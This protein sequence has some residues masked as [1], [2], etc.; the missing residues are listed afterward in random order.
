MRGKSNKELPACLE[1][2]SS[3]QF[4]GLRARPTTL[5]VVDSTRYGLYA[6]DEWAATIPTGGGFLRLPSSTSDEDD[7]Y[8]VSMFHQLHC[9]NNLRR[10]TGMSGNLS[11]EHVGHAEHCL[12]YLYQMILCHADITTEPVKW[13]TNFDGNLAKAATGIGVTHQ[14]K[15]WEQVREYAESNYEGWGWVA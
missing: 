1:S 15:N 2:A 9:L 3:T 8:A 10:F 13:I 11:T 14:C 7:Y 12:K 5:T 4:P 6:D